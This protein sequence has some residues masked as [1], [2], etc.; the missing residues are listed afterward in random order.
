MSHDSP[1]T[2]VEESAIARFVNEVVASAR[3]LLQRFV[4]LTRDS[5]IRGDR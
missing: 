3:M 4:H 5:M 1:L 2:L